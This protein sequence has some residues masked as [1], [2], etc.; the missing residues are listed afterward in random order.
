MEVFTFPPLFRAD[1]ARTPTDSTYPECQFFGSGVAGIFQWL[2]GD[3][4][5]QVR[6]T[7]ESDGLSN[8]L[9]A[10]IS[11]NQHWK[12]TRNDRTAP[13]SLTEVHR[14]PADTKQTVFLISIINK[15][16]RIE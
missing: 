16:I 9:S 8:G 13:E 3:F 11:P 15:I 12:S 14:T 7:G 10:G 2:S 1:S 5:V 6:R 4:P